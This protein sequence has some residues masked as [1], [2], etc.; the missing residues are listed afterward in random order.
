MK[1]ALTIAGSDSGGGAGIQADIKT[2]QA[3]GVYAASVI[4]AVTAQN[5]VAVRDAFEIPPAFVREQLD[6]VFA[7]LD[8]SAVKTG[9]LSSTAIIETVAGFLEQNKTPNVVVDPVMISKSGYRLLED[10]AVDCLRQ[11]LLPLAEIVTPNLHEAALLAGEDISSVNAMRDAAKKIHEMGPRHVVVKGGHATFCL[12]TDV[13]YD[14][15]SF[16]RFD[17][18]QVFQKTVHG[19][20]CTFSSAIAA[21]LAL[22]EPVVTAIG[23]AKTYVTRAIGRQLEIGSGHGPA[24]HFYFIDPTSCLE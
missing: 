18:E 16:Q 11:N 6:A 10:N 3:N 21:R 9:M 15:R 14:G 7:D 8:L 2:I 1:L 12:G 20:G 23:N 24:H 19:T 17:A 13:L 4:T 5:T 22:G